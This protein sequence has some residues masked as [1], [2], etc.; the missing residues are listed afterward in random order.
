MDLFLQEKRVLV[1]GSS[2]GIGKSIADNFL[3]EGARVMITGRS[4]DS[5]NDTYK[6]FCKDYSDKRVLKYCGDLTEISE[7]NK[8]LKYADELFEGL[9]ILI[10][11]I[12]LSKSKPGLEADIF[13]W[14]RMF[15][16]NFW[17]SINLFY[18]SIPLLRKTVEPSVVFISSIAGM[19]NTDAPIP[20]SVAK[21]ALSIA[22][23]SFARVV[24][25]DNIRV[26][27]VA[28]GNVMFPGG[29]WEDIAAEKP[30]MVRDL[31]EKQVPQKKFASPQ[32]IADLVLFIASK[33]AS[34]ITGAVITIDGGQTRCYL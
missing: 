26:N 12:G 13:E 30:E 4:E 31:L 8:C 34:F 21:G 14:E 24:A 33:R 28:P 15:K 23:Q 20:Y 10:L 19:E 17:G 25:S 11:N 29:R 16:H 5:I 2:R 9:D 7:I 18:Q 27:V 32:E 22:A 6:K 1:T 3:L